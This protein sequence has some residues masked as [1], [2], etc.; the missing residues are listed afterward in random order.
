M[1]QEK[2]TAHSNREDAVP[3]DGSSGEPPMDSPLKP[4]MW[5]FVPFILLLTYA[6]LFPT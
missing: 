3:G 2:T 6:V 4:L 1:T 5:L